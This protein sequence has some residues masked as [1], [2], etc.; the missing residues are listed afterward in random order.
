MLICV[1]SNFLFGFLWDIFGW[2]NGDANWFSCFLFF[3]GNGGG[4]VTLC[5]VCDSLVVQIRWGL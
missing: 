5:V 1:I 4:V 3:W 2:E